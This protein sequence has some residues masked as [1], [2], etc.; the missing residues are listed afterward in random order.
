M[1]KA[2]INIFLPIVL[3]RCQ[4]VCV[5]MQKEKKCEQLF[6]EVL[7]REKDKDLPFEIHS[8]E[9]LK[10]N[11]KFP[12]R[13][14][15]HLHFEIA[16][17]VSGEGLYCLEL[18]SY[19]LADNT[20]YCVPP[21]RIHQLQASDTTEGYVLS[22]YTD[23][24]YLATERGGRPFFDDFL[25]GFYNGNIIR[26]NKGLESVIG[27]ILNEMIKEFDN[28]FFLRSEV[29]SGL[30]KLF[31]AYLERQSGS[32]CQKFV[33]SR[34]VELVTNFYSKLEK[35]FL[36]R[37]TVNQYANEL[38]V[39]AGHLSDVVKRISGFSASYH[40]Q[41]R[42][43][44][45]AKRLITYSDANMKEVAYKLGFDNTFHFSKFFKK[46]AGVNFTEFRKQQGIM[47]SSTEFPLQ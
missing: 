26:V 43:I 18:D 13:P 11:G 42:M 32:E 45:E 37:M 24:I 10:N 6:V 7:S 17:V 27:R 40:I 46:V 47:D 41:Q 30:L 28:Y 29:L 16:W 35:H 21:G 20:I 8:I 2:S 9:W 31:L 5:S 39:S 38:K 4:G 23:F 34:E 25:G 44:L 19:P 14:H 12:D 15:R 36:T 33:R 3:Y 1:G 22:F